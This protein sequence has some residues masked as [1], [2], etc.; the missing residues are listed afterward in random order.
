LTERKLYNNIMT[1]DRQRIVSN[2]SI[3]VCIKK[4]ICG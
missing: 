2:K 3:C 1:M 4:I